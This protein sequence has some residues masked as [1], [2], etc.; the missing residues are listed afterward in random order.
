M[1]SVL[2]P[3]LSNVGRLEPRWPAAIALLAVG[4]LRLALP[5]TL[6]VGPNWLVLFLV[7]VLL[8]PMEWSRRENRHTLTSSLG[9]FITSLVTV[10]MIWS[11][12]LL[13]AAIPSHTEQP[14]NRGTC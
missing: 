4:G 5:A 8:I 2:L 13:V 9:Y 14:N 11:L 10:D 3:D 1:E 12:W 6:S 7:I